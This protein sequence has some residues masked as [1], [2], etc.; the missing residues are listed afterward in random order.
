[1]I[2]IGLILPLLLS[3]SVAPAAH[4]D[5]P[6][7]TLGTTDVPELSGLFNFILPIFK[8]ASNL[9]VR[10][11]AADA[12]Q[13]AAVEKSSDLNALLLASRSLEDKL[14]AD[15]Y[16]LNPRN[17]IYDDLVIVGPRLDPAGIRGLKDARKALARIAATHAS[18]A[19][20]G[21]D[22]STHRVELQLW[23]SAGLHPDSQAGWYHALG[24]DMAQTLSY[25]AAQ[26]AYTLTDRATFANLKSRKD[27]EV[28]SAG[29]PALLKVYSSILVKSDKEPP[30]KFVYSRIWHDWITN[31]HGLAAI[32]SYKIKDQ[33]IF[34]SCQGDAAASCQAAR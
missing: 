23:K 6:Y 2:R 33:Q 18:F 31:N 15:S 1:M 3:L 16:G 12:G 30:S 27:L 11:V 21:D 19:S 24:Q 32:I 9:D 5:G 26:R 13:P 17:A 4:A 8:A 14:V 20:R 7:L 22:S 28:L 10:V 34:F 25:A 29:D